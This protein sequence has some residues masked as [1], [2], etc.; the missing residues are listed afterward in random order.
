VFL[1]PPGAEGLFMVVDERGVFRDDNF[2]AAVAALQDSTAAA[3]TKGSGAGGKGK[4]QAKTV[5]RHNP[6]CCGFMLLLLCTVDTF[7]GIAVLH[8]RSVVHMLLLFRK[9]S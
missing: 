7:E 3:A 2:Q 9:A 5:R 1:L 4:S 6:A 8:M